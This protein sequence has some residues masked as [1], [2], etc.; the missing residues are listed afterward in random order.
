MKILVWIKIQAYRYVDM[1]LM[2]WLVHLVLILRKLQ[3]MSKEKRQVK[4]DSMILLQ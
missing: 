2:Y 1:I 3:T 4:S